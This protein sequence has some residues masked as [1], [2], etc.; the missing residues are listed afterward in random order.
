MPFVER[1]RSHIF[2]SHLWATLEFDLYDLCMTRQFVWTKRLRAEFLKCPCSLSNN[3]D[4]RFKCLKKSHVQDNTCGFL[5]GH[6][7]QLLFIKLK[8]AESPPS[9]RGT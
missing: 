4:L 3:T 8:A 5:P 9:S 7:K 1:K 2:H 6:P